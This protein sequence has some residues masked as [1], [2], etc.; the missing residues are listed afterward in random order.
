MKRKRESRKM[1]IWIVTYTENGE[2][3]DTTEVEGE[4]YTMAYVNFEVKHPGRIICE[5]KEKEQ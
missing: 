4:T 3:F 2:E 5:L 1:K